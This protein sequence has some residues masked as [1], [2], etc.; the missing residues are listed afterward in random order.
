VLPT[1]WQVR[2]PSTKVAKLARVLTAADPEDAYRALTTHWPD[3]SSMVIAIEGDDP[4]DDGHQSPSLEGGITEQMLWFDLVGYL[5]NDILVKLDRA[6]MAVSLETRV[7]FLDRAILDL[8]WSLPLEAKLRG[9]QSKW[10]L[11]Q[12]L[13]RHVPAA[14]VDRPKMGFGLPI[15]PWLRGKLAPWAEHL[16]DERRLR[17]QGLLDPLPIRRAWELHRSGRRDLGYELWDVLVLQ[18]WIDRWKPC[19]G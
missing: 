5:P 12:V 16:L 9:G 13:E 7:P 18:S 8:A 10:L 1:G 17:A 4:P 19:L 11:R 14:L 6:A 15:G 2:N 3:A